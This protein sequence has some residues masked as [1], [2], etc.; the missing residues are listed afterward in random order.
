MRT[1]QDRPGSDLC[2]TGQS[3]A[4]WV[5]PNSVFWIWRLHI[6]PAGTRATPTSTHDRHP[7]AVLLISPELPVVHY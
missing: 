2:P 3:G 4:S 1:S 7:V 6:S 5:T